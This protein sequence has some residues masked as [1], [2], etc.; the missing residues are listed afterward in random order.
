MKDACFILKI[1]GVIFFLA[2]AF[3]CYKGYDGMTNYENSSYDYE[4]YEIL[5]DYE[6]NKNAYVGGD[7]YNYIIN[8]THATA[9][10]VL[11]VGFLISGIL[12]IIGSFIVNSLS[13]TNDDRYKLDQINTLQQES[14][15]TQKNIFKLL[16]YL[17]KTHLTKK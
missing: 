3:M 17:V 8:G 13:L 1:F 14:L 16:S 2:F 5:G 7:A 11:A 15:A 9:F 10:F 6:D 4:N 12:C